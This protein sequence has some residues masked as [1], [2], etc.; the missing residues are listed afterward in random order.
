MQ[1]LQASSFFFFFQNDESELIPSY[2]S[3][4]TA[5]NSYVHTVRGQK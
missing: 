1:E 4:S 3:P 2:I 5:E